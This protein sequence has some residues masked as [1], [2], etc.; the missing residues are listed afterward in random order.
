MKHIIVLHLMQDFSKPNHYPPK[1]YMDIT[2]R[3]DIPT[4]CRVL[5]GM[6][7]GYGDVRYE[8]AASFDFKDEGEGG[9]L[10]YAYEKTNSID[11]HWSENEG[12]NCTGISRRSTSVG[13][14]VIDGNDYYLVDTFGFTKLPD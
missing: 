8:I 10:S 2:V 6:H 14:I 9:E 12:I 5:K 3:A 7:L 11:C 13:D 4:V 1:A